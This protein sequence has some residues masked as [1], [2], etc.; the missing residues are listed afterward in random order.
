MIS[1]LNYK[2]FDRGSIK[3]FFDLRYHGLTIKGCRLMNGSN[4]LWF[5]FP[6]AKAE[7][8]GETKYYDQ[9]FLTTPEREHVRA[10]ILAELQAQG[11]IEGRPGKRNRPRANGDSRTGRQQTSG[12]ENL[13]EHISPGD[14]DIPF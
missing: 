12:N 6:Q 5:S 4:G 8:G 2:Q 7:E 11:H 13:S 10:L 1:V 14:D 9:M 3:G